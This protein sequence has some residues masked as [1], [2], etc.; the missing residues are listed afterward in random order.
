MNMRGY[1][2]EIGHQFG[3]GRPPAG[4]AALDRVDDHRRFVG[5][6]DGG[7]TAKTEPSRKRVVELAADDVRR[8]LLLVRLRQHAPPDWFGGLS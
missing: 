4:P 7:P 1:A 2:C 5:V 8:T 3:I 6:S